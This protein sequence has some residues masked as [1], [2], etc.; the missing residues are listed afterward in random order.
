MHYG[1]QKTVTHQTPGY[2]RASSWPPGR[3]RTILGRRRRGFL[4]RR[5]GDQHLN[6]ADSSGGGGADGDSRSGVQT[7]ASGAARGRG[8][9]GGRATVNEWWG[10][11][12]GAR[13][14]LQG[15]PATIRFPFLKKKR[16]A[17]GG[18]ERRRDRCGGCWPVGREGC[19][20]K[21]TGAHQGGGGCFFANEQPP[22]QS[23]WIQIRRSRWEFP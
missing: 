4:G 20:C 2:G 8:S 15:W 10:A 14:G 22:L 16:A 12:T 7:R 11:G 21:N 6:G 13:T 17:K 9:R 23:H 18:G 1:D 3:G 19:Y 5:R